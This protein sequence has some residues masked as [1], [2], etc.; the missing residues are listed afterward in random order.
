M[1]NQQQ[2]ENEMVDVDALEQAATALMEASSLVKGFAL[3]NSRVSDEHGE[4]QIKVPG[5]GD[6]GS[7]DELQIG[8]AAVA[9]ALKD[10]G[11][12]DD[13]IAK[14]IAKMF[15]PEH[16]NKSTTAAP[17]AEVERL[18]KAALDQHNAPVDVRAMIADIMAGTA[19]SMDRMTKSHADFAA[20][21]IEVNKRLSKAIGV[22]G[23][24]LRKSYALVEALAQKHGVAERA[25]VEPPKGKTQAQPA[26]NPGGGAQPMNK[27]WAST[28]EGERKLT[29][30]QVASVL[31]Y[32]EL[33]KGQTIVAGERA[34]VKSTH[35]A[36]GG[37]CDTA[38]L[39]AVLHFL[40][41]HP[42]E[43]ELALRFSP[44]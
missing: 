15:A 20:A 17:S 33:V 5:D 22:M 44:A 8:K 26:A 4:R 7:V 18:V 10:K 21:Q 27:S 3:D 13:Q 38:T 12:N 41:T 39:S 30:S 35:I 31:S 32:M 24:E 6:A 16:A 40:N 43:A 25:P 29:A 1:G 42:T 9:K 19:M 37:S 2:I 11:Y 36:G 23:Q 28:P 34:L 14:A